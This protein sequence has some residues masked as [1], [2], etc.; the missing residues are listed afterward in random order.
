MSAAIPERAAYTMLAYAIAVQDYDNDFLAACGI[1]VFN[2]T[3]T[4]NTEGD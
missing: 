3:L 1:A 4:L 2:D